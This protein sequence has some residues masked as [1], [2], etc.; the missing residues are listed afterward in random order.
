MPLARTMDRALEE[1]NKLKISVVRPGELGP[2]EIAVWLSMQRQTPALA[3]PFLCP[4]FTVAVGALRPSA[5]VAVL[6]DGPH[7]AGFFPFER[8]GLFTNNVNG[9][10]PLCRET[11]HPK[12]SNL[13][14]HLDLAAADE[15]RRD[16]PE[17]APHIKGEQHDSEHTPPWVASQDLIEDVDE[18]WRLIGKCDISQL[19]SAIICVVRGELRGYFCEIAGAQAMMHESDPD[20]PVLGHDVVP[21]WWNRPMADFSA[22]A[23]HHC[24]AC[25]IPLKG[26]G[27]K[28]IGGDRELV[29]KT[30]AAFYRPKIKGR[31]VELVTSLEQLGQRAGRATHYLPGEPG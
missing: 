12:H 18:R 25:G 24:H 31:P 29:S 5:R 23:D 9:H 19:W 15:I 3:N 27:L 30:H 13:N 7:L 20:W 22:Q 28:A 2:G 14:V 17:A 16:W 10:G 8:R 4:D 26:K 6:H 11:F 21:G 1:R